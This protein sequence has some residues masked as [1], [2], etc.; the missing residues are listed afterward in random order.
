VIQSASSIVFSPD[1]LVPIDS[2]PIHNGQLVIDRGTVIYIG[3]DLPTRYQSLPTVRLPNVAILPGLVNSHC[4]LEFSDLNEPI[5]AGDSFPDWI[6]SLLAYR[7]LQSANH[8]DDALA[9]RRSAIQRGIRESY[10]AGVRWVVDMVTEPWDGDWITES[11]DAIDGQTAK[12]GPTWKPRTPI[13]IQSCFEVLDIVVGRFESAWSLANKQIDAP[14]NVFLGKVGFA[15]H[16]PYTT[17]KRITQSCVEESRR[18]ERLVTM[19]LAESMDEMQWI[20]SRTGPFENLLGPMVSE[21]Y[22][23]NMGQVREHVKFLGNAWRATVAHGNYLCSEDLDFMAQRSNQIAIVHCPRTHAHFG[24]RYER[25]NHYPF[26]E[27]L[28]QGVRHF[29]GTDSRASNPDLN[30]WSEAIHAHLDHPTIPSIDLL[31]MITLDAAEFLKIG[32]RYG[33][34]QVGSQAALTAVSLN[35]IESRRSQLV[36]IETLYDQ[37]LA[38]TSSTCPLERLSFVG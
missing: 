35:A 9:L 29:L 28:T 38:P 34:L 1:W 21:D 15:P 22:W 23:S 18:S 26:A 11:I 24:H 27:R 2:E 30:V 13:A 3:R 32:D 31:R 6:R 25:R 36:S 4:H 33:R 14:E 17:S 7:R 8:L 20:N 37:L 10:E 12:S 5:P 19:H 16:A